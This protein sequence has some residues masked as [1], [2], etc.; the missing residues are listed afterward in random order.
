MEA[1]SPSNGPGTPAS[2]PPSLPSPGLETARVSVPA[3][4]APHTHPKWLARFATVRRA[5]SKDVD[6]TEIEGTQR[7]TAGC[8]EFG[9][10]TLREGQGLAWRHSE[11]AGFH[12]DDNFV[13]DMAG[14]KGQR[15]VLAQKLDLIHE[16]LCEA[17]AEIRDNDASNGRPWSENYR[18]P[19]RPDKPEGFPSEIADVVI[20]CMD[21]AGI[22]GFDLEDAVLEKL[23]FNLSRSKRHGRNF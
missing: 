4:G 13:M 15:A 23:M 20:R 3:G 5:R 11:R 21:L 1:P 10:L 18:K 17:L 6:A 16:E 9:A 2:P 7:A 12:E 19:E 8:V 22:V 14:I